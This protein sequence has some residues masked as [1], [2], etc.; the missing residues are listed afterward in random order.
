MPLLSSEPSLFRELPRFLPSF[1]PLN[2]PGVLLNKHLLEKV[3]H[4]ATYVGWV[5]SA[6]L[7][8]T[9]SS[10]GGRHHVPIGPFI[11]GQEVEQNTILGGDVHLGNL[12]R[13]ASC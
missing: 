6:R 4:G 9:R 13:H 1:V 2:R 12:A 3:A 11:V 7:R 8:N 10:Q 5:L